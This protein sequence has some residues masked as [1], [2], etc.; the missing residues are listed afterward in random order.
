MKKN[1]I[2]LLCAILALAAVIFAVFFV[3]MDDNGSYTVVTVDGELYAKLPLNEDTELL[4]STEYGENL[5][6]VRNGKVYVTDADCPDKVCVKTGEATEMIS[7][8]CLP[9]RLT[10]TVE[11]E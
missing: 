4:V 1:D 5:V 10:V 3:I 7:I 2:L 8:V 6:T 11:A 9:H